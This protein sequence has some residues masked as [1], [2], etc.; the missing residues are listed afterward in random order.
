MLRTGAARVLACS[1]AILPLVAP[2]LRGR[3]AGCEASRADAAALAPT[4]A[5]SGRL[6]RAVPGRN[7]DEL[8]FF[9]KVG[10]DPAAEDYRIYRSRR[11]QGGWTPAERV[12]LGGEHSD[13]YPTL[14]RDG[15]RLVFTSYR[16]TPGDSSAHPNSHLW[17]AERAGDGWGTPVPLRRAN[18]IGSYHSQ[19]LFWGDR[20]IFRRT[21]PDWRT[22]VTLVSRWDGREFGTAGTFEPVERWSGLASH[23][24][25]WGGI[26]SPDGN[27]VVL[28]VSRVDTATKRPGPSDLWASVRTGSAWSE[29][30]PLAAGVNTEAMFENFPVFSGNGCDLLFV[31]DFSRFYRVPLP[32]ALA[33]RN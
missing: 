27:T 28:E 23:L 25:V 16:R 30:R 2:A 26:P 15:R 14:S 10:S 3:D 13:L 4:L 1:A 21:S 24:R 6:F 9:K 22:T 19:P 31:R 20:L 12:D 17:Y 7:D 29:P 11:E 32:A 8:Y 18:E 5:D 33:A